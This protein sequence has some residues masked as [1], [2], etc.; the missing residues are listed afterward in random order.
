MVDVLATIIVLILV[1]KAIRYLARKADEKLD[2]LF[3]SEGYRDFTHI[4][5][6]LMPL[7]KSFAEILKN[8]FIIGMGLM[9]W[10]AVF[11]TR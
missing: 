4:V 10:W 7:G 11:Q 1:F 5:R 6:D 9:S 2:T 8:I 3:H